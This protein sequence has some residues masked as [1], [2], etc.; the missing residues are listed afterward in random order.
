MITATVSCYDHCDKIDNLLQFLTFCEHFSHYSLSQFPTLRHQEF[1]AQCVLE[2][3]K[4]PVRIQ[5]HSRVTL[6][7]SAICRY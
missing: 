4:L 6:Q 5:E 7:L 2:T 1:Q 3:Q